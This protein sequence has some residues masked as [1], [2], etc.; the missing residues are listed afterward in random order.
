MHHAI[1]DEGRRAVY[2]RPLGQINAGINCLH[3]YGLLHI[4][5]EL[6]HVQPH[7]LRVGHQQLGV[8]QLAFPHQGEMQRQIFVRLV[9]CRQRHLGGDD[10]IRSLDG[11]FDKGEAGVVLVRLVE[12]L[13]RGQRGATIGAIIIIKLHHAFLGVCGAGDKSNP[14]IEE[15]IQPDLL[16]RRGGGLVL[17]GLLLRLQ[18]IGHLRNQAGMRHQVIADGIARNRAL[19]HRQHAVA[20]GGKD[21]HHGQKRPAQGAR[22]DCRQLTHLVLVTAAAAWPAAPQRSEYRSPAPSLACPG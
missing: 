2:P 18:F 10:G 13:H 9:A 19:R 1:D 6:L 12:F 7:L 17:L 21:D 22:D 15:G 20:G 3:D 8:H 11:K 14:G 16:Y 5:I 4:G